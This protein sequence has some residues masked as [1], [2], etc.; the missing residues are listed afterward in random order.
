[1]VFDVLSAQT[2]CP[3]LIA[4]LQRCRSLLP[5]SSFHRLCCMQGTE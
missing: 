2:R 4:A 3:M 5:L 1:M